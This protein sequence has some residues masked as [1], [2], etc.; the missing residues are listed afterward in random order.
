MFAVSFSSYVFLGSCKFEAH[1]WPGL[2]SSST[3]SSGSG[4]NLRPGH[5]QCNVMVDLGIKRYEWDQMSDKL[6][7]MH[8]P[9]NLSLRV[10]T[11]IAE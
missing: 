9:S 7:D 5:M 8:P 10:C 2:S 6:E 11:K 1:K 4:P 3:Q